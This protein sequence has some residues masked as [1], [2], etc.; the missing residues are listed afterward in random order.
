MGAAADSPRHE[1]AVG[2]E[3]PRELGE[4]VRREGRRREDRAD[5]GL[6]DTRDFALADEGYRARIILQSRLHDEGVVPESL[7]RVPCFA[8]RTPNS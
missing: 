3:L 7:G 6:P 4:K 2:P 1:G 5:V 8:C